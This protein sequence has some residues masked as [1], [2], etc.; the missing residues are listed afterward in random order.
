MGKKLKLV[1]LLDDNAA[2]NFIHKKFIAKT[3]CTDDILDFQ[4]G[5]DVLSYLKAPE[6]TLPEILFMDINMPIMDA[7]EFLREFNMLRREGLNDII[8]ILLSTSMSPS[9][10]EKAEKIEAINEILQKP[11]ST[12]SIAA[13][14]HK[15]FP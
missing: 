6:N 5:P 7:W 10:N 8:I 12:E 2:T 1:M 15:Y 9:D 3:E 13:I 14:I 4:S 11:L